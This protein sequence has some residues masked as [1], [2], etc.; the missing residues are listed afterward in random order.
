MGFD[1]KVYSEQ[2]L[3]GKHSIHVFL[4]ISSSFCRKGKIKNFGF[5]FGYLL[6]HPYRLHPQI[7]VA[8][9]SSYDMFVFD[10]N[11]LSNNRAF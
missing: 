4:I 5:F 8:M 1:F 10:P 3:E 6:L 7:V 9:K 2:T 11:K